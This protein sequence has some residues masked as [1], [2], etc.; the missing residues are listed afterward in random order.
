MMFDPD[1]NGV[2]VSFGASG[3]RRM[4]ACGVL[5]GLGALLIYVALARP[6]EPFWLVF[7]LALGAGS[8]WIG[9]RL[10][11]ATTIDIELTETQVCDSTGRVLAELA[12]VIS[13]E[14][15]AFALKPSNGFTLVL[16]KRAPRAWVPGMWW[17]M[18]N[19]VG[20][21]G[22]TPAGPAKFMAEQVALRIAA[23][24]ADKHCS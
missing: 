9:E 12:D 4:F 11:R 10:R 7:L 18:G 5:F 6:P 2:Y 22:T 16:R 8:L 20:V 13:V 1:E 3:P 17:R 21:G 23:R 19:R 24:D 14:R 15:G